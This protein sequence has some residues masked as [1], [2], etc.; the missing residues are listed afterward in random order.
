MS[1]NC[2][3]VIRRCC[4]IIHRPITKNRCPCPGQCNGS[5]SLTDG[6]FRGSS[7]TI[8]F[9][10]GTTTGSNFTILTEGD[11]PVSNGFTVI[12]NPVIV[13]LTLNGSLYMIDEGCHGC[14]SILQNGTPIATF[15]LS[16]G[17][18]F[19]LQATVTADVETDFTTNVS[20]NCELTL[21]D[22]TFNIECA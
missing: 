13:T 18:S 14:I 12:N 22:V 4:P 1:Q 20:S 3:Q 21:L 10:N 2:C 16:N 11:P 17:D 9:N 19:N 15:F 6:S 8:T 5:G 7:G